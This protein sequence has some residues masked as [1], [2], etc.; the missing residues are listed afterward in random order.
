M[1]LKSEYHQVTHHRNLMNPFVY[2]DIT[3]LNYK[4]WTSSL[5]YSPLSCIVVCLPRST[6]DVSQQNPIGRNLKATRPKNPK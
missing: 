2:Y 5:T 4:I 6:Q 1:F 3:L